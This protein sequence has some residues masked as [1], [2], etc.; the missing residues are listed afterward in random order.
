MLTSGH[1]LQERYEIRGLL[2]RGGYGAVY[3]AFHLKLQRSCAIKELRHRGDPEFVNSFEREAQLLAALSHPALP[4]VSDSFLEG[5]GFYFV[6]E[7]IPGEDL[8]TYVT[9]Q[10]DSMIKDEAEALR[11]IGPILD[12]LEYLHQCQPAII[13][14]D[15]KPANIR[16][17]PTGEVYLVDF[18]IAKL[19]DPDSRTSTSRQAVT[20]GYSPLEQYQGGG[21]TA[22]SSD[23]YALGATLYHMLTGVVP[24]EAIQRIRLDSLV[25]ITSLNPSISLNLAAVIGKMMTVYQDHRIQDIPTL[26]RALAGKQL[27]EPAQ[28]TKMIDRARLQTLLDD[29]HTEIEARR[30]QGSRTI[31]DN[32]SL[33]ALEATFERLS[34]IRDILAHDTYDL[35]FIGKVGTGKTTAICHLFDL[36]YKTRTTRKGAGGKERS[37]SVFKELLSTGSGNTTICEVVLRPGS[38]TAIEIEPHSEETVRQ[39]IDEF[40]TRIWAKAYPGNGGEERSAEPFPPEYDKAVRN[41]VELRQRR[42]GKEGESS[43]AIVDDAQNFAQ[44]F[45]PDQEQLFRTTLLARAQLEN[46]LQS[47]VPYD[48]EPGNTDAE[49]A[50]LQ[51]T[52]EE[53]NLVRLPSLSIPKC[54]NITLSAHLLDPNL[55]PKLGAVIDTRGLG[56]SLQRPDLETYIRRRSNALCIFTDLF[57]QAPTN[58]M[59]LMR[60][61]LT[62][63]AQDLA[64]KS[65]LMVLPKKGEPEKLMGADGPVNDRDK[66]L[67]LRQSYIVNDFTGEKINFDLR[68]ILFYDALQFYKSDQSRDNDYEQ[69]DIDAVRRDVF[70]GL[71]EAL[72]KREL[73]LWNEVLSLESRIQAILSGTGLD[74]TD[75]ELIGQVKEDLIGYR[76]QSFYAGEF[77]QRYVSYWM[78]PYASTL[79][80]VNNRRGRYEPR[81][82]DIYFAADLV[83]EQHVANIARRLKEEI[84]DVIARLDAE[85]APNSDL[86]PIARAFQ[87]RIDA[88]FEAFVEATGTK[89][90]EYIE[91]QA[92]APE[93]FWGPVQN[94]WGRGPGYKGDVINMYRNQLSEKN[95]DNKLREIA[96]RFWKQSFM[97]RI[98]NFF[99]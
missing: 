93:E 31:I 15:I 64:T 25:P 89:L 84:K 30:N 59:D 4:E 53:V 49:R 70:R 32:L 2:G 94:R 48:G 43:S 57:P 33:T 6:M 11:L 60:Q 27:I 50:W 76:N 10:P 69:E 85:S 1:I 26:R 73:D 13:H 65:V 16:L 86:K 9:R 35:V 39:L 74:P 62:A 42:D 92:L 22:P 5:D 21:A 47:Q 45:G 41:M 81:D 77:P 71:E 19:Y 82:I 55:F 95:A 7:Y 96:E 68:N 99:G 58:V 79:R 34:A 52:F 63:E 36:I 44:Q 24:P 17:T 51:K 28:D 54:I 97:R 37:V 80:A 67:E 38:K 91:E 83:A 75:E 12:A 20:A 87:E 72:N 46:R 3:E 98:L 88:Y 18:G 8:G 61:Y 29:T 14:R 23:I 56:T 40:C 78:P 66:G 90:Q